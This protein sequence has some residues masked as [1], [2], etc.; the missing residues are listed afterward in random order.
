[1]TVESL[2]LVYPDAQVASAMIAQ[3]AGWTPEEIKRSLPVRPV[4]IARRVGK[5]ETLVSLVIAKKKR[6][7]I[8]E[9]AIARSLKV[10]ASEV[11]P[12]RHNQKRGDTRRKGSGK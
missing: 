8:V 11:F 7:A 2:P 6:S 5:S 10:R 12:G 3:R 4:E 1:M 9:A